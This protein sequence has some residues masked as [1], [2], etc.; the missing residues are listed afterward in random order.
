MTRPAH[1]TPNGPRVR[2]GWL[3]PPIVIQPGDVIAT[4]RPCAWLAPFGV[5]SL[6]LWGL[7]A[8]A[9][10]A[11]VIG[12]INKCEPMQAHIAGWSPAVWAA[13]AGAQVLLLGAL[14]SVGNWI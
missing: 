14:L 8:V 13:V 2:S 4:C 3:R 9:L 6:A 7:W 1:P 5:L 10:C 11:P 12:W